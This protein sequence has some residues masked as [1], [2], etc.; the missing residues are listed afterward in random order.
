M[1][2]CSI[3]H[4]GPLAHHH[5]FVDGL[6]LFAAIGAARASQ[7]LVGQ[8]WDL[9]FVHCSSV[10]QYVEHVREVP[11]LLDFGDMDSHK[12]IEYSNYKPMPM[13][14]GYQ[15]EG[16]KM[17]MAEKRLASASTFAQQRRAPNGRL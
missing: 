11:K 2:Q 16:A 10:A 15:F 8:R 4:G 5:A 12:W 7:R 13:S 6:L 14:W 9:I 17:L 1:S 3:A